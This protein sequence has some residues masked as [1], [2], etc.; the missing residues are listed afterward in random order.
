MMNVAH[1]NTRTAVAGILTLSL[2]AS[3]FLLW[4]IYFKPTP[5]GFQNSFT[6][7]PALNA[8]LNASS[9]VSMCIGLYFIRQ[10]KWQTHR[11]F[12]L[13][14][15]GFSTM[16]L[17]GYILHHHLHGDTS[18]NGTGTI[19]YIYFFILITHVLLS[20]VALPM[21]LTTVFLSL[22]G[23]F[24]LHK[25]IARVTFPIWLYVSVTGVVVFF[26]LR[27]YAN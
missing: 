1:T 7:L 13:A 2:A 16:F 25:R 14:A 17:A 3:G 26:L 6:F 15:F 27:N 19:R 23:R 22:T 21:I 12:M 5:E 20:I 10:K 18:F 8:V 11:N 4:L 9:A 24:Q